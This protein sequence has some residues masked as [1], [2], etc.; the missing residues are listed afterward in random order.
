MLTSYALVIFRITYASL[1]TEPDCQGQKKRRTFLKKAALENTVGRALLIFPCEFASH[2]IIGTENKR[3][4]GGGEAYTQEG[5][6]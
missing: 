4:S 6:H 2:T 1:L 5:D 3:K